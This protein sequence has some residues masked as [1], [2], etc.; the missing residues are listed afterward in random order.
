MNKLLAAARRAQALLLFIAA[1]AFGALAAFAARGYLHEQLALE[2]ERLVPH[3]ETARVVVAKQDLRPGEIVSADTMAVREM[4]REYLPASAVLEPRF[5]ALAGRRL[6][7]AMHGGEPLLDSSVDGS[8]PGAFSARVR[9]GIRALTIAV[10]ETNSISGMLQPGDRIDLMLSARVPQPSGGAS[11]EW[12]VPLMSD[13]LVLATGRQQRGDTQERTGTRHFTSITVE[14]SPEQAQRLVVAQRNGRI[15]AALRNPDDRRPVAQKP[16]DLA[17]LLEMRAPAAAHARFVP[18]II[19]GGK[20]PL[21]V[22]GEPAVAM[23]PP[24]ARPGAAPLVP[25]TPAASTPVA[26]PARNDSEH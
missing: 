22:G 24:G 17:G 16:L 4:P 26:A 18:E 2:R 23:A 20:G 13:V 9:S 19:V 25:A 11:P 5:A 10:D 3:R 21:T 7:H 12:T 8:D 1:L 15:T 14:V 6:A